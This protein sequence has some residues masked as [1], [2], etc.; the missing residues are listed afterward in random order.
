MRAL[1]ILLC[2]ALFLLLTAITQIGGVLLLLSWLLNGMLQQ[3]W[4]MKRP[5]LVGTLLFAGLYLLATAFV[6][7]PLARMGGRVP[8]PVFG[9]EALAPH[10]I[11]TA[12]L[13]RHYVDPELE[14]VVREVA[15]DFVRDG[16]PPMVYL[17]AGAPFFDGFPLLPH[18]SHNDGRKLD[19]AFCYTDAMG[20]ATADTP[21]PIGYGAFAPPQSGEE[22]TAA[23]CRATGAWWY[24]ALG[25]M[26]LDNSLALDEART[27]DLVN[28]LAGHPRTGKI[29]IEPYLKIR[30]GISSG[31]VRFHGCHA[32][33][34]ADHIHVQL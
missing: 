2:A 15:K 28:V 5:R 30:W 21:S 11:W 29:F 16:E 19:L 3:R 33:S 25:F 20:Q 17:D 13:N 7:P 27:R 8:L 14:A 1:R 9:D 32:V 22:D 34:H 18:L 10:T 26:P 31:K 23:R 6:V 12:V 24:D 4:R